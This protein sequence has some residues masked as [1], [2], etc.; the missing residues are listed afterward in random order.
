[1]LLTLV[2][3]V[4]VAADHPQREGDRGG[5]T[6]CGPYQIIMNTGGHGVEGYLLNTHTGEAFWVSNEKKKSVVLD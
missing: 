1:M 4:I 3:V 6:D 5:E 2:A